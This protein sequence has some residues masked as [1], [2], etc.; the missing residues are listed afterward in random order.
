[1]HGF[2]SFRLP[3][4]NPQKPDSASSRATAALPWSSHA[5]P[6]LVK[7]TPPGRES[8]APS[9]TAGFSPLDSPQIPWLKPPQPASRSHPILCANAGKKHAAQSLRSRKPV[10]WHPLSTQIKSHASYPCGPRK[11]APF[12]LSSNPEQPFRLSLAIER[13]QPVSWMKSLSRISGML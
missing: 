6:D 10:P 9:Q 5:C 7:S 13:R 4:G 12:P 1:M 2:C 11:S 8:G 3:C